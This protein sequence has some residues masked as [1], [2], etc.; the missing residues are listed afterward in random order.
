MAGT[1][2][3]EL[4][5]KQ[6]SKEEKQELKEQ[7]KTYRNYADLIQNGLY[8]RLSD[9]SVQEVGAWEFVSE[10]GRKA[11]LNAVVL[12]VHGNMTV[13]YIRLKGLKEGCMYKEEA[14]GNVYAS[15]ALMEAGIPLPSRMG[16]YQAYQM[17][18]TELEE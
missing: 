9:P 3:Y 7:M 18:F 11:L 1:F 17:C 10:D 5:P 15:D 6:L 8:Y 2:G 16:D 4:D 13:N 12:H 14:S